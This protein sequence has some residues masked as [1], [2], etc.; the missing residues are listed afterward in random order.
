[1][2]EPSCQCSPNAIVSV[3][4]LT[5]S[6][7]STWRLHESHSDLIMQKL[8][9]P[10]SR[11]WGGVISGFLQVGLGSSQLSPP[12]PTPH[13]ASWGRPP[14]LPGA[15]LWSNPISGPP[16]Y[17]LLGVIFFHC[18]EPIITHASNLPSP[19]C[20]ERVV[21]N[22]FSSPIFFVFFSFAHYFSRV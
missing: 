8:N 14:S 9:L 4:H 17:R 12:S 13:P 5:S 19:K 10:N 15:L 3:K 6:F 20:L 7:C 21:V 16:L 11:S 1:M 22:V 2:Y 18:T